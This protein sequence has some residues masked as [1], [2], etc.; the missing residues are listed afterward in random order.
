[1]M[2]K[3][4]AE[5]NE[6]D[7]EKAMMLFND[8]WNAFPQK[9]LKGASPQDK[10]F[11]GVK[12]GEL[13]ENVDESKLTEQEKM[14]K[15]HFEYAEKNLDGYMK[16]AF[17]EVMPKYDKYVKNLK[18]D[19]R[20]TL[21]SVGVAGV[22]LEICGQMGMFE[23]DKLHPGFIEDFPKLFEKSVVGPKISR[24]QIKSH[25][26]SFISFLEIFYNI[27]FLHR[28]SLMF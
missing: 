27:N 10:F 19:K 12:D 28:S 1:M 23:F 25:I 21:D 3:L 13:E 22:F 7:F 4:P 9:I 8:A 20:T 2:N 24:E 18:L 26:T 14:F 17:D 5:I 15:Q 11:E 6:K 16:W